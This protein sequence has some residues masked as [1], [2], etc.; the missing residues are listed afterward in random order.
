MQSTDDALAAALQETALLWEE[1]E[2]Y[3]RILFVDLNPE[4]A[5]IL[6]ALR[7]AVDVVDENVRL[8]NGEELAKMTAV[9]KGLEIEN[10]ILKSQ[11][12]DRL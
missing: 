5:S 3:R 6:N 8:R 4:S 1:V 9:C 7:K 10:R 11:L 12:K 2:Y